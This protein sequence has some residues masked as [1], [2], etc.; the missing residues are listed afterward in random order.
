MELKILEIKKATGKRIRR[1]KDV[2]EIMNA[3]S[4]AD[5]ECS[6][7][8]HL[9]YQHRVI[10]KEL[11][12]IGTLTS[13]FASPREIFKKALINSSYSIICIHNHPSGT[14]EPS[15]ADKESCM[16]LEKVGDLLGIRILD[17]VIIGKDSYYSFF[18]ARQPQ[19]I[20]DYSRQM[21]LFIEQEIVCGNCGKWIRNEDAID[22]NGQIFC[23]YCWEACFGQN[24]DDWFP[25]ILY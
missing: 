10:E 23:P 16:R 14:P 18:Q 12:G 25:E 24:S 6:W 17:Y 9:N 4:R 15:D 11:A 7:V 20:E 21:K 1:S 8:L 3:E 5:R 19:T 13:V 22:E 2:Y